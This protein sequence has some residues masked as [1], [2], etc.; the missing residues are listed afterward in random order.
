[1]NVILTGTGSGR[2][3][4]NAGVTGLAR[5]SG[6]VV[7]RNGA[8]PVPGARITVLD[9][10]GAVAAAADT[11]EAGQYAIE[12]LD[13]GEYTAIT[14]GYPPTASTLH[15]AEREGTARHD[16]ELRHARADTEPIG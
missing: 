2:P 7:T 11:D 9:S 14:S 4:A 3:L 12:G 5:L 16:V 10:T 13:D 8:R 1:V 6:V 15:I